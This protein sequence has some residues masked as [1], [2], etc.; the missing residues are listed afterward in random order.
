MLA[1]GR[2]IAN[3]AVEVGDLELMIGG[4]TKREANL[5]SPRTLGASDAF[6]LSGPLA[7]VPV[8]EGEMRLLFRVGAPRVRAGAILPGRFLQ[9]RLERHAQVGGGLEAT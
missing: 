3:A 1:G 5:H 9:F 2:G 8:G 4:F 7:H 6:S